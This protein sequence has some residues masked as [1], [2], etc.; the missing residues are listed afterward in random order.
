MSYVTVKIW[1][2]M[3]VIK[4]PVI[5]NLLSY[6]IITIS[7]TLNNHLMVLN[8]YVSMTGVN[9]CFSTARMVKIEKKGMAS[10]FPIE[11]FRLHGLLSI[12]DFIL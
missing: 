7:V 8:A 11:A 9:K 6:V 10:C 2:I 5:W 12:S 4:T 3:F 1:Y